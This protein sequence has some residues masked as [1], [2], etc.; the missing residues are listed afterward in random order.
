MQA[1]FHHRVQPE[2]HP[3]EKLKLCYS[4]PFHS[5]PIYSPRFYSIIT[6]LCFNKVNGRVD[7]KA[8][9]LSKCMYCIGACQ[10]FLFF[11]VFV[12]GKACS[13][14]VQQATIPVG[15]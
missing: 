1:S 4:I 6:W 2:V 5:I 11:A 14:F 9:E 10:S 15:R 12:V 8:S 3:R 7:R 13:V